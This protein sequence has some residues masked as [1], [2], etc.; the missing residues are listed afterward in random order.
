MST[1]IRP[2]SKCVWSNQQQQPAATEMF[3]MKISFPATV[4]TTVHLTYAHYDSIHHWTTANMNIY[5]NP[6]MRIRCMPSS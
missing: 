2:E 3:T 5:Y 1:Q 6:A 4:C